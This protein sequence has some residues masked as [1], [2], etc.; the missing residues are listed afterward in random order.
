[1]RGAR[2]AQDGRG[3]GSSGL[4]DKTIGRHF[5]VCFTLGIFFR[6]TMKTFALLSPTWALAELLKAKFDRTVTIKTLN[7]IY[8]SISTVGIVFIAIAQFSDK[9][10]I[11]N[12]LYRCL[13]IPATIVWFYF[14][15]SRN[16]EIFWA[17]LKD[18][19]DKMGPPDQEK[20]KNRQIPLTP[21]D[22]IILSLKSYLELVFNFATI[23]SLTNNAFWKSDSP[24]SIVDFIYYS[25]V[26]ITTTGYGDITPKHYLPQLLSVY[27]VFC[28]VILLVVC[29]AI[30]AGRLNDSPKT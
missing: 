27:E 17:F 8:L 11:E 19:F 12:G 5:D 18:A 24:L 21:K 23:Y 26:T 13:P 2:A 20:N 3:A 22:R 28:G 1:M 9:S 7:S 14:V 25:G 10:L 6:A 4:I 16:N 15:M 29:F 30:Y